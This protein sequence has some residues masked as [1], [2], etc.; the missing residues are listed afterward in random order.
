MA[1]EV[2]ESLCLA[3]MAALKKVPAAT[4]S[5]LAM[6][7]GGIRFVKISHVGITGISDRLKW[8][9]NAGV[10][11]G[12]EVVDHLEVGEAVP[13]RVRKRQ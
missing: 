12:A 6:S 4:R 13:H 11:R 9:H 5:R 7:A 10:R 2:A 3:D 1:W 8:I